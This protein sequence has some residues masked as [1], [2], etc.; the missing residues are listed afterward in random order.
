MNLAHKKR[1]VLPACVEIPIE[2][3]WPA[4]LWSFH[5]HW[6]IDSDLQQPPPGNE[7]HC[8][9]IDQFGGAEVVGCFLQ[10]LQRIHAVCWYIQS[11]HPCS[12]DACPLQNGDRIRRR[13]EEIH[14]SG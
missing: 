7:L 4:M 11:I 14:I 8:V 3:I 1:P 6:F 12:C 10:L 5:V 13:N 2:S 9:A